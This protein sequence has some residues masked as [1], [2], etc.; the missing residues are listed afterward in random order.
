MTEFSND[1][2][3]IALNKSENTVINKVPENRSK[4]FEDK[5]L[6]LEKI[7]IEAQSISNDIKKT[8]FNR[9]GRFKSN[10]SSTS[11]KKNKTS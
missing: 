10:L 1:L 3:L 2:K 8:K 11:D 7:M 6:L 4:Q 5:I 9:I